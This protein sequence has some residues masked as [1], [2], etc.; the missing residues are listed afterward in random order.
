MSTAEQFVVPSEDQPL[1]AYSEF[2]AQ[3]SKLREEN[4]SLVFDYHDPKGNKEA[5]SHI[6]KLR[7]TKGAVESVRKEKKAASLAYGRRVDAEAKDIIGEIE[8]MIEVHERPIKEIEEAEKRRVEAIAARIADIRELGDST[9]TS[10]ELRDCL[11]RLEAITIDETFAESAADAM[12]EH[13]A[14]AKRLRETLAAAEKAEA[15]AA[16]LERLR[17]ESAAREQREREER[18]AQEAAERARK[19]AEEAAARDRARAAQAERDRAAAEE[20]AAKAA[21]EAEER[22][23]KAAQE[24]E[25]R[26]RRE[27]AE[28]SR[29]EAE[30][31]AK[32]EADIEHR[33]EI[34]L[35][36]AAALSREA[37]I[38]MDEARACVEAIARRQVPA[39]TISY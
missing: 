32:R 31:V 27:A 15:E 16:E 23:A 37:N 35:A 11:E 1:A 33:R 19:E 5:R 12:V 18:I 6:H 2:R 17:A 21:Q 38:T 39:V 25:E 9:G 4:A 10:A 34:N 26:M 20:R 22:A 24:A 7:R 30:E 8:D 14:A 29:R 28:K 13:K 3:L 36:A